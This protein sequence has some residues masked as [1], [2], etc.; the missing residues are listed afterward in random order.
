[1]AGKIVHFELPSTD[2]DRASAFWNGLFGW[3]FESSA[4]EEFDYRMSPTSEGCAG[5]I[6]PDPSK[7]GTGPLVYFDTDD[8]DAS[9]AQVR[10]LGGQGADKSPVGGH[11]WFSVCHDTE[12]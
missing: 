3:S 6:F 8:V 5:A 2:A 4:M 1:M 9:V 7:A 12:G 10:E 11:G